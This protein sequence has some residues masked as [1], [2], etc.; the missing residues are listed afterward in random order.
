MSNAVKSRLIAESN[1]F[2][3]AHFSAQVKLMNLN[4]TKILAR[5]ASPLLICIVVPGLVSCG[6]VQGTMDMLGAAFRTVD[7]PPESTPHSLLRISTDG[8]TWV[9]PG[10]VCE[11]VT[12]PRAGIA[13]SANQIYLGARGVTN[14]LRGVVGDAPKGVASGELRLTAGEPVTLRYNQSWRVG[15][16]I[17]HCQVSRSFVPVP[18]AQYQLLTSSDASQRR[19]GV[20]LM[21]LA[22]VPLLVETAAAQK[23]KAP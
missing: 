6:Q 11:S 18:G 7:E 9:L 15:D 1:I 10:S 2:Q 13:V 16:Y 4:P 21:Q 19:C 3:V 23:C 22:P 5:A 20:V 14:Q 17:Y 8:M 12:N